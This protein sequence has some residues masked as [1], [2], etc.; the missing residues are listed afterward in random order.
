[1]CEFFDDD[2][3]LTL[4]IPCEDKPTE[5]KIGRTLIPRFFRSYF[6]GGVT[7]L[8]IKLRNIRETSHKPNFITLDCEQADMITKHIF[9]QPGTNIYRNVV[10]HT[11]GHL[12]LD[13]VSN[14]FDQLMIKSWRFYANQCHEYIDRSMTNT[15]LPSTYLV[16]PV[17]RFG[18]TKSTSAYLRMCMVMEPMQDL[19]AHHIQTKMDP[20]SC[21]KHILFDRYKVKNIE[22][23]PNKR[24]KRKTAGTAAPRASPFSKKAKVN[25]ANAL[26]NNIGMNNNLMSAAD[27]GGG[28]PLAS[29]DVLVVGEPSMLGTDFGDENERRI[30]RLEN[31]QYD[32]SMDSNPPGSISNN[33]NQM[34]QH[35]VRINTAPNQ[36]SSQQSELANQI[37]PTSNHDTSGNNV[38]T[39]LGYSSGNNDH[40][41]DASNDHG[42]DNNNGMDESNLGM[43]NSGNNCVVANDNSGPNDLNHQISYPMN[44]ETNHIVKNEMDLQ[45]KQ[46]MAL[47]QVAESE[48]NRDR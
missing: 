32:S 29:Q 23:Q 39:I 26:N 1:M 45:P 17:T 4:R 20:K 27:L 18:L 8:S 22:P 11:E 12:N 35:T 31:N 28:L 46:T 3:I 43:S 37:N 16:E 19:M 48:A 21:L 42:A 24:R 7:D 47:T 14:N 13:F 15:G 5:Y 6:E 34:N 9:K 30:T 2:S 38:Q 10:V 40:V 44:G 33:G 36:H 25:G 41:P